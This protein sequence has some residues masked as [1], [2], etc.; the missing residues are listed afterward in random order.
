MM[1]FPEEGGKGGNKNEGGEEMKSK[2]DKAE[3]DFSAAQKMSSADI[4]Q[5]LDDREARFVE[6]YLND[7]NGTQAAIRAGY[8]AGKNNAS[9]SVQASRLKNDERIIAYRDALLREG[10]GDIS[11][12]GI[13]C[14]LIEIYR[15]C[16]AAV[17]VMEWDS[18]AH[19]W[20][21]SGVWR[22][23]AKGATKALEQLAKLLGFEAPGKNDG[24]GQSIEDVMREFGGR[25][26]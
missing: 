6:E 5:Y 19:E 22:F 4:K 14:S 10:A 15:R 1:E 9:A 23:D 20:V 8:K 18:E 13:V 7:L 24:G 26:Y 21:E 25:Q 12:N 2:R 17:P 3:F 16:M 11:R